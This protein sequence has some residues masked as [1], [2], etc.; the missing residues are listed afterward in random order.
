MM[1]YEQK[2]MR[3]TAVNL[4]DKGGHF[5]AMTANYSSGYV[6]FTCTVRVCL[7]RRNFLISERGFR[8]KLGPSAHTGTVM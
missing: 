7:T 2:S 1:Q 5:C 3:E 6:V 8:R 4:R